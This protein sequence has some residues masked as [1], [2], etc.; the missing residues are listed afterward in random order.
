MIICN[1]LSVYWKGLLLYINIFFDVLFVFVLLVFNVDYF[2][3]IFY[4][5]ISKIIDKLEL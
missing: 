1:V 5:F 4:L 2:D 3:S